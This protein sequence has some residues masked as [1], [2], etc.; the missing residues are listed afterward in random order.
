MPWLFYLLGK[1]SWFLLNRRLVLPQRLSG[2]FGGDKY[3]AP[4]PK[5]NNDTVGQPF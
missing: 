3:L 2:N 5:S 4:Y 1:I